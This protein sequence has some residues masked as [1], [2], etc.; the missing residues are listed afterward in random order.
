MTRAIGWFAG[1]PVAANLLMAVLLVGGFLAAPLMPQKIFPDMDIGWINI[2][3]AYPSAAP[4]E[5][6]RGVCVRIEE[7]VASIGSIEKFHSK[8]TEGHCSVSL[9]LLSGADANEALSEVKT[10]VDAITTFPD[11]VER[12]VVSKLALKRTVIDVAISGEAD[13]TTLKRLG[14]RVR[15]DLAALPRCHGDLP[16]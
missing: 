7:E 15:D 9:E 11:E 14:E 3:V 8:S 5:V 10:R 12:L 1:N 6:E 13:E 4:E 2:S 16:P